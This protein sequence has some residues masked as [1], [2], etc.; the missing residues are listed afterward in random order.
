[1]NHN[2]AYVRDLF[3][4]IAARIAKEEAD[5]NSAGY[6]NTKLKIC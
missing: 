5:K 4:G 1:M 6:V 2:H 3:A